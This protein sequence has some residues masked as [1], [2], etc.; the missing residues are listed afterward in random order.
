MPGGSRKL[1]T[2]QTVAA[3]GGDDIATLGVKGFLAESNA[4]CKRLM[5]IC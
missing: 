1:G 4:D 5:I 3:K 2:D